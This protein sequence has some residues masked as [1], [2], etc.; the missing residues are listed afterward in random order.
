MLFR[1]FFCKAHLR[2]TSRNLLLAPLCWLL[3]LSHVSSSEAQTMDVFPQFA[4]GRL[5]DGT[6]YRTTLMI[7]NRSDTASVTC[8]LQLRG[9][10]LPGFPSGYT[11]LPSG[12]IFVSTE[13]TQNI[14]SGY[15]TL[16]CNSDVD[17]QLLYSYYGAN[18]VKLSE[19]TVFS[20]SRAASMTLPADQRDGAEL[21]LAIANDTDQSVN[22]IIN[23]RNATGFM[24]S[25]P[26]T[27]GPRSSTARFLNQFV[28]GIP[29]N[30]VT[31]ATVSAAGTATSIIGLRYTGSVFTTIPATVPGAV[32]SQ[33][34]TYH[35]FP[36]FADGRFSD[37]TSYRT[38][39]ILVNPD[40]NVATDCTTVLHGMTLE[41]ISTF[42]VRLAAR[43]TV[44]SNPS[45]GSQPIQ[46]GY[47]TTECDS[48]VLGELLYSFFDANGIKLSEATV[49][50]SP[51]AQ[52]VQILADTR[53][54]SRVGLAI[55]N[56][57]NQN[58]TYIISFFD[59]SGAVVAS[60]N[61]PVAAR[62]SVAKFIDELVSLP[63][64]FYGRVVVSSPAGATASIIGLRFTG[65]VFTTIPET[66]R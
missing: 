4:D 5:T 55:A 10:T 58:N 34:N 42:N 39:R 7:S 21:G 22:Y 54:G 2:M 30:S 60:A 50:S 31:F 59:G 19:A 45:S 32:T 25:A 62:S 13:G 46:S 43:I 66:I 37:G 51:S 40:L 1:D 57:T 16:Q 47:A 44:V 61:Q 17:A 23:V 63:A 29:P 28:P 9:L 33:A 6:Y 49:F 53:G 38:T 65:S 27:L 36:Q 64:D 3:V 20:S 52:R 18:G 41:G 48:A 24:A 11:L 15:A 12:F 35:V 56:D 8:S 26:V 14:Q